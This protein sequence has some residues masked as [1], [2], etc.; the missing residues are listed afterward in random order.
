MQETKN[1]ST[2][3]DSST[4]TKK[5]L[6][7]RKNSQKKKLFCAEILHPLWP[8]VFKSAIT[9][10]HYFSPKDSENLKSFDIGIWEVGTKRPLNGVRKCD[11]QTNKHTKNIQ[12]FWLIERIGPEGR[13][14][15]NPA[16][17]NLLMCAN[18]STKTKQKQKSLDIFLYYFLMTITVTITTTITF[19]FV[20]YLAI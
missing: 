17:L 9:S 4:N 19:T 10:F 3:A 15:E 11:G 12:K 16:P 14:F 7:V 8:K 1:L 20:Y 5:I 18:R 6:L 2:D 13:F